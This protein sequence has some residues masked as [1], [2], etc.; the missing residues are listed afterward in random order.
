MDH[1]DIDPGGQISVFLADDN[2]I[3]REGVR[4]LI[5][6]HHDLHVVG[7]AADYDGVVSGAAATNPQVCVPRIPSMALTSRVALP[8]VRP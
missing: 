1:S 2:L 4:A 8:A 7:V 3:V 6:R 5:G